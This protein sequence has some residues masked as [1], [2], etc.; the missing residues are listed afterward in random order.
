MEEIKM[1]NK[2]Y[3]DS[4][5][6]QIIAD[7]FHK[8]KGIRERKVYYNVTPRQNADIVNMIANEEISHSNAKV[9]HKALVEENQKRIDFNHQFFADFI[10]DNPRIK[11]GVEKLLKENMRK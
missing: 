8:E 3:Y 11:D 9:L 10:V 4:N 6:E 5:K 1:T 2:E 7:Y